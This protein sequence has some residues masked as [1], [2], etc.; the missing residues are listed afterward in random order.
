M[1]LYIPVDLQ[2]ILNDSIL[3]KL[4]SGQTGRPSGAEGKIFYVYSPTYLGTP[5][6]LPQ[7]SGIDFIGAGYTQ[8]FALNSVTGDFYTFGAPCN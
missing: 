1:V 4:G 2:V 8:S 5:T 3:N 6:S 7:M